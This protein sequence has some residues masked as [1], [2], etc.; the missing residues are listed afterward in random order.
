MLWDWSIVRRGSGRPLPTS[1]QKTRNSSN[2]LTEPTIRS[3]S[4]YL[5]LLKWK[6]P[7]R[8]SAARIATICSTLTPC[9]WWP[10]ST[11]TRARSPRLLADE[12][13]RA[14][15][16]EVG[17]VE[18][19][20]EE[21]VLDQQLLLGGQRGVDARRATSSMRSRRSTQVVLARVV[22]AVGEPQRL[23][24]SSR[25]RGRSRCTRAGARSAL[26]ADRGVGVRDRAE[27][28]VGILEEVRV[29]GA[30]AQAGGLDVPRAARRQSSTASHGKCS[31]TA[32]ARAGQAVHLGGVVDALEDVRGRPGCGK[33]PKR[34]PESP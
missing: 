15:V 3:S 28:V 6:P 11:S 18:R 30:D 4:A 16:G 9:A 33:T 17:R 34:V 23:R 2:G 27:H 10:M 5:R 12:Q 24:A 21:L 26:R 25:A 1:S 19:G 8:S 7:S 14:P 20:L 31:A 13:R 32:P 29:D 22:G